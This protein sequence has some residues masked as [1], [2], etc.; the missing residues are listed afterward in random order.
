MERTIFHVDMD[1]FYASVEQADHPE[2]RG[3]PVIIGGREGRGVVSACSYEA[4]RFGVHSAMP[5]AEARRRC[6]QGIF[7][8]VN[9]KRYSRVSKHIMAILSDFAPEMRQ[10]SVDEAFLDMSGTR[11]LMGEP[12]DIAMKLKKRVRRETGLTISIGIAPNHLLAKMASDFNKPD[13]LYRV[14]PGKEI[15]FIDHF[16]LGNIWGIGKKS[17]AQLAKRGLTLPSQIRDKSI[18]QLQKGFGNS[19]GG[20]LYHVC[21]GEDPGI[22]PS[23]PANRSVSNEITFRFDIGDP[24][25]LK[26]KLLSLAHQVMFRLMDQD[27]S[28]RT[29]TVKIRYPDF[30]TV[31]ARQT[32]RRLVRSGEEL[33]ARALALFEQRWSGSAVRLIGIGVSSLAPM[34]QED[35]P[36]LFEDERETNANVERAVLDIMKKGGK[37][38]KASLLNKGVRDS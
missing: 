29:V 10:I 38:K 11:R 18:E 14:L 7:L 20:Y 1:A 34:D 25:V 28:G 2:L 12:L 19:F 6:P 27:E 26:E 13:G 37:I 35:E 5:G 30:E 15:E 17:S 36:E 16:K 32:D 33:F 24:V 9:M 3:K 22:M 21:R 31:S 4:R 8:P 23:R